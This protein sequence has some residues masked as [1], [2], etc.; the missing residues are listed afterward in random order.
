MPAKALDCLRRRDD[1]RRRSPAILQDQAVPLCWSSSPDRKTAPLDA[2]ARRLG[3]RLAQLLHESARRR[4]VALR[5]A[6]KIW[7]RMDFRNR[8]FDSGAGRELRTECRT[9]RPGDFQPSNSGSASTYRVDQA[10][11]PSCITRHREEAAGC[12]KTIGRCP[13]RRRRRRL[14]CS[15]VIAAIKARLMSGGPDPVCGV[16]IFCVTAE[17]RA[18]CAGQPRT[19]VLTRAGR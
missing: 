18:G 8:T 9:S 6:R 5:I 17:L 16:G 10:T 12:G 15:L 7:L 14:D 19:R 4:R 3:R 2:A 13:S 1:T 11:R